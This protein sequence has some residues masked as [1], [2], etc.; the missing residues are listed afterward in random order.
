MVREKG[1]AQACLL[2]QKAHKVCIWPLGLAEA[3][4]AMGSGTEGSRKPVP[5]R[6]VKQRT[7][8]TTNVS[9]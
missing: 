2:C 4:A 7:A 1:K 8:T 5:R 3:T 6:V 9:P